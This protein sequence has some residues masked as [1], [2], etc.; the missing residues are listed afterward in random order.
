MDRPT[1]RYRQRGVTLIELM[2]VVVIIGILA[3]IAYPSYTNHLRQTRRSDAKTALLNI[4]ARQERHYNDCNSYTTNITAN[5]FSP[6]NPCNI[7][8]LGLTAV[9]PNGFYDLVVATTGSGTNFTA[10]AT[11]VATG[12]Q[13]ADTACA[14][15]VINQTGARTPVACWSR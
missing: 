8:G 11:P 9:S 6:T 2:I 7:A 4:A 15:L 12:P 3:A 10:T 5:R 1:L 13:A 14:S